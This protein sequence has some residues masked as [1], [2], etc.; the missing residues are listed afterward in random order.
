MARYVRLD[1]RAVLSVSGSDAHGFL[2]GL[3]TNDVDKLR[4]PEAESLLDRALAG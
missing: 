1:D 3:I 4:G 2:Q